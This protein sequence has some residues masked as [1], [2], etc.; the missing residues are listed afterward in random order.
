[1]CSGVALAPCRFDSEE[2]AIATLETRLGRRVRVALRVEEGA[3]VGAMLL[4]DCR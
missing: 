4:R 2:A 3:G 1:M